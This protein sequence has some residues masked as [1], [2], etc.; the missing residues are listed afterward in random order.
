MKIIITKYVTAVDDKDPIKGNDVRYSL[1]KEMGKDGTTYNVPN[2][3][4]FGLVKTLIEAI[5]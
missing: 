3:D 4:K 1:T 5:I 2:L